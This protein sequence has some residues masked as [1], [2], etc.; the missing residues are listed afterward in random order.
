MRAAASRSRPCVK[1][2]SPRSANVRARRM[3][4]DRSGTGEHEADDDARDL[5][6]TEA[7]GSESELVNKS[8]HRGD[9]DA[10]SGDDQSKTLSIHASV[11]S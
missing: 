3:R 7:A 8:R 5:L 2:A 11:H 4:N 6:P 10:E 1:A 9:D